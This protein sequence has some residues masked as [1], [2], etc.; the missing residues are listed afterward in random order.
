M[1]A[2]RVGDIEVSSLDDD[3]FGAVLD[4]T[5]A[6]GGP[7]AFPML[8]SLTDP[9]TV[10]EPAALMD[11]LVSLARTEGGHAVAVQIGTLRDDLMT[12]VSAAGEG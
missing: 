2:I 10:V 12:A 8:F 9:S 1:V 4:A 6:H 3:A 11:E 7:G 5:S